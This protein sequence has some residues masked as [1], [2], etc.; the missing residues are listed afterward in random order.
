MSNVQILDNRLQQNLLYVCINLSGIVHI[1]TNM[2]RPPVGMFKKNI[3]N[4]QGSIG[5]R[6]NRG[7]RRFGYCK[8]K[9]EKLFHKDGEIKGKGVLLKIMKGK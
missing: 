1:L 6:Q 9:R 4:D 7:V 2:Y 8:H 5:E 3:T